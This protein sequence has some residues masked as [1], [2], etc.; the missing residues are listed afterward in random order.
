[1]IYNKE[2]DT[3]KSSKSLEQDKLFKEYKER[4]Q[5]IKDEKEIAL[6]KIKE[7][8]EKVGNFTFGF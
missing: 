5:G 6:E 4:L 1:M 2:L 3:F 8:R 7:E